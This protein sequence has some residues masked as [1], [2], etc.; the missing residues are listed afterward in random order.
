M[1]RLWLSLLFLCFKLAFAAILIAVAYYVPGQGDAQLRFVDHVVDVKTGAL[2]AGGVAAVIIAFY[3]FNFFSWIK[4]LPVKLR[5]QLQERRLRRAR[6]CLLESYT[7]MSS[8]EL[9][10]AIDLAIK[11]KR[12]GQTGGLYDAFEAQALFMA[13]DL[14]RAEIK[15]DKLRQNK[16]TKFLG[17]RGLITLRKKQNRPDET[18][19][20]LIEALKD[21]PNSVWVLKEL[22]DHNLKYLEFDKANTVVEQLRITG[23]LNKAQ[24]NRYQALVA[25]LRAQQ[26]QRLGESEAFENQAFQSLKLDPQLMKATL[27]LAQHYTK[28]DQSTKAIKTLERGYENFPHLDYLPVLKT[29][30]ATESTL[31]QYRLVEDLLAR[32]PDHR[33]THLILASFAIE[34]KLWGQ[35]RL[36]LNIL[37]EKP[38]QLVYT[39]LA[40]LERAEHPGNSQ[41]ASEY[42]K[43]AVEA[44]NEGDWVCHNCHT[45]Q[46]S[47]NVFCPSCQ[48]FDQV[49]WENTKEPREFLKLIK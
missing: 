14:D 13:G 12:L 27:E 29:V 23:H 31:D 8:G 44:A 21:R 49:I 39:L 24:S 30:F 17:L 42:L 25:W 15:F 36:H 1:K 43:L 41:V 33:V 3:I 9:D 38:T 45:T 11:S 32:Q 26:F 4:K 40:D 34:A 47:W 5:Q 16:H 22:L 6:E 7:A 19:L 10:T 46:L 20:L 37:K 28:Q 35:A 18:R 2:A 48:A